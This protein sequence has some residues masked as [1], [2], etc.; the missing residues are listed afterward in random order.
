M[1]S[2]SG[3]GA[4]D[5]ARLFGRTALAALRPRLP[6]YVIHFVTNRC[7]GRCPFC[8]NRIH[9]ENP[10]TELSPAEIEKIGG[11]WPG[12][13][14]VTL[15][16]GEPFL[17]DDFAALASAWVGAGAQSLAIASNG[18]LPERA[19][20]IVEGLLIRHPALFLDLDL[21]LDGDA[22]L[23]DR[24]RGLPG[25]HARVM[26][27]ASRLAPLQDRRRGFRLGATLTLSATN[28]ETAEATI[29]Q[30]KSGGVFHRVQVVLVRGN[31]Y[32][33]ATRDCDPTIY[34]RC[35]DILRPP[36][37]GG[38]R[39][40]DA[41][42]RLVRDRVRA[43]GGAPCLAGRTMVTLDPYG[44]VLPCEMLPQL[45]RDGIKEAGIDGWEMGNL[46]GSDYNIRRIM[47]G[48]RA[49]KIRE[50][51]ERSGCSCTF[52]CALYNGLVFAPRSW[53]KVLL[54]TLRGR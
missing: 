47:A 17:R 24:L 21:S 50:W 20:P 1:P 46:R 13:V 7:N 18:S 12:L 3:P 52:E 29:R 15:T 34:H 31:P 19:A 33:P 11:R 44:A 37:A 25:L 6:A 9:S 26:D 48:E 42:S 54:E 40:R 36:S 35:L 4:I 53:P 10:V 16:G 32:D 8:F 22:E 23:H 41:L 45:H 5:T 43:G 2:P 38:S 39:V 14:H 49:R 27:L 51:I 30:L 28:Q